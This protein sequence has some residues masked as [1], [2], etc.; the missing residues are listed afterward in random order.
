MNIVTLDQFADGPP[1]PNWMLEIPGRSMAVQ[2]ERIQASQYW[3]AVIRDLRGADRLSSANE[4]AIK[5]LVHAYIL[6]DRAA[7]QVARRG[8]IIAAPKTRTPM[9]NPWARVMTQAAKTAQN[10][11]SELTISPLNRGKGGKVPPPPKPR[12]TV[13]NYLKRSK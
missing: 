1:E 13:P 6:Y 4:H 9:H 10:L 12:G 3:G 2:A 11:E 5:R 7:R 8:S